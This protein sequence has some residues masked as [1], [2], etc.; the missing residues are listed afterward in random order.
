V[1]STL[2]ELRIGDDDRD[3]A[4][5]ALSDHYAAG[6]LT[7]EE[8][9]DRVVRVWSAR[10]QADLAPLFADLPGP[11]G[12]AQSATRRRPSGQPRR[13]PH[14]SMGIAPVLVVA[15]IATVIITGMPWLLFFLFWFCMLGGPARWHARRWHGQPANSY[16]SPWSR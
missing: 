6:R 16:P 11:G 8:F 5:T 12:P 1:S 10:F 4:A 9:D 3:Q 7:K 15:L 13:R 2:P 14:P